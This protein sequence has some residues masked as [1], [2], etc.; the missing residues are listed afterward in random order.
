MQKVLLPRVLS[1]FA[2]L[3][4][5][6][7][8]TSAQTYDWHL[9]SDGDPGFFLRSVFAH[10]YMHGYEEGFHAGD[11]DLQM[12]RPF[13]T[14]TQQLRYK[15]VAGYQAGFGDHA[16]FQ[17]GYRKGYAVGYTDAYAGRDFR[18]MQLLRLARSEPI[19]PSAS[20]PDRLFDR[21]FALGYNDGTKV[22]LDD[23]RAGAP[24]ADMN[25]IH[26]SGNTRNEDCHAYQQGYRL[27]YSDGYTNQ[28][29]T[30]A[31]LAQK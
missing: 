28:R 8:A 29:D 17:N 1:L 9:S 16:S 13:H 11:L 24:L 5:V 4:L 14:V 23:G 10:G 19:S 22:G 3:L 27:G 31:V 12:G 30:G 25:S 2:A 26:C 15:K 7:V 18:A 21:A 20:A 6:S